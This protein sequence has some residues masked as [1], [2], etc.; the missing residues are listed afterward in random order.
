MIRRLF[1]PLTLLGLC[2]CS[3]EVPTVPAPPPAATPAAAPAQAAS[4]GSGAAATLRAADSADSAVLSISFVEKPSCASGEAATITA[5]WD[6]HPLGASS[7]AVY[8]ES[9]TNPPK[10]WIEAG[11]SGEET[12]GKWIQANT[13]LTVQDRASGKVLA[14]RLLE[15]PCTP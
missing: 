4:A 5:K 9:P 1:L 12:T 3:Q 8:V 15:T 11:A 6:V 13:R 7:V 14:T 2:A 10:L